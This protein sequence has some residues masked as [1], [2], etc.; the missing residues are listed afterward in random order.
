MTGPLESLAMIREPLADNDGSF[1]RLMLFITLCGFVLRAYGIS[2][3]PL[4]DDD[5]YV[6]ISAANFME[7]GHLG[8]TMWNHPVL[9]NILV[10]GSLQLFGGGAWG[11]KGASL[12]L[13]TLS[14]PL[15]GLT[16]RSIFRGT[17]VACTAALFL[18]LDPLHIDYSRQAVQEVYMMFF[19]LAG[20]YAALRFDE[21]GNAL[22]LVSSG[23]AFGLGVASKWYV[24]FPL[25]VTGA[26]LVYRTTASPATGRTARLGTMLGIVAVFGLVPVTTYLLTFIPWFER[27]YGISEW[28]LLQKAMYLESTTHGGYNPY[29]L[30]L[31]HNALVWFLKP[32]SY[33]DMTNG[34]GTPRILLGMANPLVWLATLPALFHVARKALATRDPGSWF[35]VALFSCTYVP[36]V[37]TT[38]PI[39]AHTAFSVL[40]FAFMAVAYA[41]WNGTAHLA[42]R[43]NL[44]L[45]YFLLLAITTVPLYVLAIGRGHDSPWLRAIVE[46][47]RPSNER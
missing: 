9:R 8:P 35:L 17:A 32:V 27:G 23:L 21:N 45:A 1:L 3:Q 29:S 22:W 40:P 11:L 46:A 38:R 14:V 18:A 47:Y 4:T 43:R 7:R 30:E 31:D 42:C 28:L 34:N 37:M 33:S 5:L 13:G 2:S 26:Y 12:V 41:L 6:A 20:I 44:I 15:L 39:W 36:F 24:I 19:G 25:A 10:Y 16:A